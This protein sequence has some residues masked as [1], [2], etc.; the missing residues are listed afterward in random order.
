MKKVIFG[1]IATVLI[2]VNTI[3]Q[4]RFEV[5]D[6][7]PYEFEKSIANALGFSKL[8]LTSSNDVVYVDSE[9]FSRIELPIDRTNSIMSTQ[10]P[11]QIDICLTIATRKSD[12]QSGIGFRCKF[13]QGGPCSGT[14]TETLQP[15][16]ITKSEEGAKLI[17]RL[18][19]KL[20][21]NKFR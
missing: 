14:E 7:K 9:G 20:D 1:L 2:S 18:K 19:N 4:N 5:A 21:W 11:I 8:I 6:G 3:A 13:I 10:K 17:I 12:C 16:T 15:A